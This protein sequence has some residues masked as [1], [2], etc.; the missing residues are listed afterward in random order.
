MAKAR[1][2]TTTTTR[3]ATAP[4]G[5]TK[6]TSKRTTT[7]AAE[8]GEV[9]VVE[10]QTGAGWETGVAVITTLMLLAAILFV[11]YQLAQAYDAGILF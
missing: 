5:A 6:T 1:K 4:R 11:D 10:E 8:P 9:E 7:V 2:T 3:T